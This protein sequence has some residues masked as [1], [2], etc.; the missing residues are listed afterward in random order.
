MLH[1]AQNARFIYRQW[2][3]NKTMTP[4]NTHTVITNNN[5]WGKTV[6]SAKGANVALCLRPRAAAPEDGCK[7][8]PYCDVCMR[9][10][11]QTDIQPFMAFT[12][13][14][15][16]FV[17]VSPIQSM[18]SPWLGVFSQVVCTN[19]LV[20][21][22]HVPVCSATCAFCTRCRCS[23]DGIKE[24]PLAWQRQHGLVWRK[25]T[26]PSHEATTPSTE[27][28][29]PCDCSKS[30]YSVFGLCLPRAIY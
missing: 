17:S 3:C 24:P 22:Y 2:F 8:S 26:L 7:Q 30:K 23:Q 13:E 5:F 27:I 1:S 11:E 28:M 15:K 21:I 10:H 16:T 9:D 4:L 12:A 25:K 6:A 20:I 18:V 14:E 19:P 29:D